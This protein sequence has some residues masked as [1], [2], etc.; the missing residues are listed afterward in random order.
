MEIWKYIEKLDH[1]GM[2]L[3]EKNDIGGFGKYLDQTENTICGEQPIRI[4]MST[5]KYSKLETKT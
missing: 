2:K 1:E 3:I 4:L 5:I